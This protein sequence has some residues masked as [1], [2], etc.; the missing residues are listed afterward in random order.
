MNPG[1][2][3]NGARERILATGYDLFVEHG[4]QAVGIDRVVAEAGVAKT[5]LYHHFRSKDELVLA[6]LDLRR[7]RWTRDWLMRG[8]ESRGGSP[9]E[10]L[11]GIFDLFAEWFRRD[12]YEGCFFANSLLEMRDAD[13]PIAAAAS[14]GLADVR[15]F[16]RALADEAGSA[17]P[18][19]MARDWQLLM[20]GAILNAS[21]GDRDAGVRGRVIASAFLEA[22]RAT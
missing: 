13:G 10:R 20:L 7:L 3:G 18:D 15:T 4:I 9:E 17:D 16:L 6:A 1:R 22:G 21:N 14:D 8:I 2:S 5:T 19:R 12:D 11:L